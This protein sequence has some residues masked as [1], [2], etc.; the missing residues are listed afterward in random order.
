LAASEGCST[1]A[2]RYHI[3]NLESILSEPASPS[4]ATDGCMAPRED[5]E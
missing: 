5:G 1:A 3:S 4:D 2:H